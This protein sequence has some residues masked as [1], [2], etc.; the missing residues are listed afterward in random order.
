[1]DE[2][3]GVNPA[4]PEL[5]QRIAPRR[6]AWVLRVLERHMSMHVL[7]I[8]T[9]CPSEKLRR[10]MWSQALEPDRTATSAQRPWDSE[11]ARRPTVFTGDA[12]MMTRI[13]SQLTHARDWRRYL[14]TLWAPG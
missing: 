7:A 6:A 1:M 8:I 5:M 4:P 10:F 2:L 12:S 11:P 3:C 14:N 13:R 9:P